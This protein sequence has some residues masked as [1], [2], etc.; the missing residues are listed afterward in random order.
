LPY[1]G[2][3][4]EAHR[5]AMEQTM[6]EYLSQIKEYSGDTGREAQTSLWAA[7]ISLM[8]YLKNMCRLKPEI[9]REEFQTVGDIDGKLYGM[10]ILSSEDKRF[11][12]YCWDS[13]T[14]RD[15]HRFNSLVQYSREEEIVTVTWADASEGSGKRGKALNCFSEINTVYTS[16]DKPI[17]LVMSFSIKDGNEGAHEVTAYTIDSVL[18]PVNIFNH[19]GEM[20]NTLKVSNDKASRGIWTDDDTNIKISPDGR[21]VYVPVIK[22][23]RA[24]REYDKNEKNYHVYL[25]NG[26]EFVY[27]ENLNN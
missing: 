9:I 13:W 26:S 1:F 19:Y 21:A 7:N 14:N 27:K 23:G 22:T 17:Y 10:N 5:I 20:R 12:I 25:F 15:M 8:A 3:G 18:R 24:E 6:N 2:F 4:Q 16:E 11:R